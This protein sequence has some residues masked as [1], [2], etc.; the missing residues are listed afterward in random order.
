MTLQKWMSSAIRHILPLKAIV[1]FSTHAKT[2]S[3]IIAG[4]L[5]DYNGINTPTLEFALRELQRATVPVL[6]LPGNHDCLSADSVY[7][8]VS[9]SKVASNVRVFTTP[10]GERFSFP[11]LDLAVWGKP[12]TNYGAEF[13]PMSGIPP[14]S[15]EGWQ[16]A[17]AHGYYVSA[18]AQLAGSYQIDEEEI[19]NSC[20]D[21]VA[22]G[23]WPSFRCICNAPVK[24]FYPGSVSETGTAAIVDF[25]D[26]EGIKVHCRS[27][28][29]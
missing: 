20:Q 7:R 3:I 25:L 21:Y 8:R 17:V 29:Q 19:V 15:G 22:L 18:Q 10:E 4:D 9:F 24:A 26:D 13:C 27:I 23:H 2:D 6:I 16:I 1:D 12:I 14:R 11:E 28:A 5:F